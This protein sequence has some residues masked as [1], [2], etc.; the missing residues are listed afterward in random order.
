MEKLKKKEIKTE[1][2]RRMRRI[3]LEESVQKGDYN[4]GRVNGGGEEG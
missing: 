1:V 4:R 3:E 2:K